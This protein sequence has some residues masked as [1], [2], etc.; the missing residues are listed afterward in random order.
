MTLLHRGI[1]M[2]VKHRPNSFTF[3]TMGKNQ[4]NRALNLRQKDFELQEME[5]GYKKKAKNT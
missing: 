5:N 3:I 4:K 2:E 1:N